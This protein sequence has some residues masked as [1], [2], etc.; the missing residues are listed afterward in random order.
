MKM[1]YTLHL[2]GIV[3][4]RH[5]MA[6]TLGTMKMGIE[7]TKGIR[8]EA[9]LAGSPTG[10]MSEPKAKSLNFRGAQLELIQ[11]S[12]QTQGTEN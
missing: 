8:P 11:G 6:G 2:L 4:E 5:P 7:T 3:A 12:L 1:S 9:S 10:L